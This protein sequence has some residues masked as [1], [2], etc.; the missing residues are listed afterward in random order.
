MFI[1]GDRQS[2]GLHHPLR[3][4]TKP[5][6]H[7]IDHRPVLAPLLRPDL[8]PVQYDH[9]LKALHGVQAQP[10]AAILELFARHPSLF[11][12]NGPL[13]RQRWDEFFQ[14]ADA[15]CP[16]QNWDSAAGAATATVEAIKAHLDAC[17]ARLAE[18]P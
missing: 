2:G 8:T 5:L 15:A 13:S 7:I 4:G 18:S 10:Q 11:D 9:A 1:R 6:H 17:R 12:C 16:Q 3:Q 14:F